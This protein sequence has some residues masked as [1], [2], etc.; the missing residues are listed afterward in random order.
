[1]RYWVYDAAVA[2]NL[3]CMLLITVGV[4][5]M[6]LRSPQGPCV[7]CQLRR[8]HELEVLMRRYLYEPQRT[9]IAPDPIGASAG[10]PLGVPSGE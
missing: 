7:D 3:V 8:D 10:E 1:M 2:V 5:A 4:L 9:V 6:A